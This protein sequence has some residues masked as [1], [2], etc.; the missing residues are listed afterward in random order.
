VTNTLA[1]YDTVRIAFVKTV[2]KIKVLL[3]NIIQGYK[4]LKV[5]KTLTYCNK[6]FNSID[7][8][9]VWLSMRV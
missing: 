6:M 1:Y 2:D 7:W 4:C 3:V 5:V 8:E 9:T